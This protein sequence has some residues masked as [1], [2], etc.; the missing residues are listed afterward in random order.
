MLGENRHSDGFE[1]LTAPQDPQ[2]F[3]LDTVAEHLGPG[4][5]VSLFP[6]N[7]YGL[8]GYTDKWDAFWEMFEG[9]LRRLGA[10]KAEGGS[11]CLCRSV[12]CGTGKMGGC[13]KVSN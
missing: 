4:F 8:E 2:V 11:G 9:F 1:I 12:G 6:L 5:S 3:P 10:L 7:V 13:R